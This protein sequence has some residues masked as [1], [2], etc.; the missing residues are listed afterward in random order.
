MPRPFPAPDT[1]NPLIL[2]DGSVHDGTV[3]LKSVIDHPRIDL[4]R[5]RALTLNKDHGFEGLD[6]PEV[7]D[8]VRRDWRELR[9]LVNYLTRP[10]VLVA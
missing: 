2:P 5:H 10:D 3:F 4:L 7:C 1:R 6:S 8:W 9:P